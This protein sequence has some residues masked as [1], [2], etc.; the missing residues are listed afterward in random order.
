M[1]N[2]ILISAV[3]LATLVQ[4]AVA[5]TLTSVG[6]FA[7]PQ[8]LGI[9]AGDQ[10][11]RALELYQNGLYPEARKLFSSVPVPDA[12]S[13]GYALMCSLKMKD[14]DSRSLISEYE[15]KWP[16][17][18]MFAQ[19]HYLQ[20]LNEFD[21]ES[22]A[23]ARE[24]FSRFEP[25]HLYASQVCEYKFKKAYSDFSMG[26]YDSAR[27]GFL[28]VEE[29]PHSSF[30]APAQYS[31]AYIDYSANDFKGAI[32]RFD[33]AGRDPRFADNSEYYKLECEFMLKDYD[34]VAKYGPM[35]F[36]KAPD[37]RRAHLAR[38]LSE[39]FLVRGENELARRYFDDYQVDG[40]TP[41]SRKDYFYAGS[42]L[43]ATGDWK[44]AAENY[45]KM[46][47]RSDSLG[48][49]ASYN[50]ADAY[51]QLKN[52]VAAMDAFRDAAAPAYDAD[53]KEDAFFN[54]AK[55][56]FDLNHDSQP[57][58]DYIDAYGKSKRGDDIYSYMALA[59][60]N[61]RDYAAAVE[62]YDN[63]DEFTP[64]MKGNYMKAN[65]L[66][67]NQLINSGSYRDAIQCLKAAAFYAD[68]N[69]PVAQLSSYWLAQSQYR[70]GNYSAAGE[71]FTDLYNQSALDYRPEGKAIPYDLAY[72][73]F[74]QGDYV[75]A[76]KWFNV[77]NASGAKDFLKDAMTRVA[78]CSF[79][80][81]D[82][83]NAITLYENLLAKY[84]DVNDVYPYYQLG[85]A[86]GLNR[87]DKKKLEVLSRVK[88]ASPSAMLYSDALYELGRSYVATKDQ[89][90]AIE[91]FTLL[92]D[93][94]KDN[95]FVAKSL[96]ELGMI[97]RN[98]SNYDEALAYY[99]QVVERFPGS[100]NYDDALVA[101]ESIY[102]T[103][104]EPQA[105]F[106]YV[107]N[108][109]GK[110]SDAEKEQVFFNSAEEIY[111]S[112]NYQKALVLLQQYMDAYPQGDKMSQALLYTAE[113]YKNI[114]D[115]EKACDNYA[116]VLEREKFGNYAEMAL[117]SYSALAYSME[118]YD[119]AYR[120]YEQLSRVAQLDDNKTNAAI[121]MM[122]AA[123]RGHGY[124][125]A[126][127]ASDALIASKDSDAALKREA[128]WTKAKSCLSLSRRD[129]AFKL[130]EQLSKE[131]ST[132]EGAEAAYLVIQDAYDQGRFNVI[133]DKVYAFAEKAGS[134]NY[135]L[136][137]AFIVLGDSFA[138]Q[139]NIAQAKATFESVANGYEAYGPDDDVPEAVSMRLKKL[140]NL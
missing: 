116:M 93:S 133:E 135:W 66:R 105:Y 49:I 27:D 109:G 118:R 77:Y 132:D 4:P 124:N 74:D 72:C 89:A 104:G 100:E 92:K 59:A 130:L 123:Y 21:A 17:S 140:A 139:D 31:I 136:A 86:Y 42:L 95:N 110:R 99:K 52:K 90:K 137:K 60:L 44:G 53:I 34:Y 138:E 8:E 126:I 84:D 80:A 70:A 87:N 22:Y 102:Q 131:P 24:E 69:S 29:M 111:V 32:D 18:S 94:S 47:D 75:N 113:C 83:P 121:G 76:A 33:L 43:Y 25:K 122:R 79:I 40:D 108:I 107:D 23:A 73:Y 51:I 28:E 78:D 88:K 38:I 91:C 134:Q 62:A 2:K 48:Q 82:Y 39:T 61:N 55:L 112:G 37:E 16:E 125:N 129:E 56:A 85:L 6:Q 128:Q 97:S 114:G 30:T 3:S 46:T 65:Y 98:K 41:K 101:I 96:I 36:D 45:A 54:Y 119:D 68:R 15:T 20:G 35:V 103:K 5:G 9:K 26:R 106:A 81:A 13:E 58:L 57:F 12:L 67:A 10:F 50:L 120:A 7:V 11:S 71:S 64:D 115:K 127:S 14:S 117:S 19:I 1:K 63:I